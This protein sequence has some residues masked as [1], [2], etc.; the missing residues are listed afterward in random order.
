MVELTEHPGYKELVAVVQEIVSANDSVR[1][2]KTFDDVMVR[3][4]V[5]AGLNQLMAEINAA[6]E[7]TT[8]PK[9][10]A[11]PPSDPII[12]VHK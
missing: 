4:G 2:L 8:E 11:Q 12:K 6:K 7:K 5:I 3:R 10:E 9:V 1:G